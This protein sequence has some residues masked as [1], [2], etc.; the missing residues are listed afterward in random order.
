ML[1]QTVRM[2]SNVCRTAMTETMCYALRICKNQDVELEKCSMDINKVHPALLFWCP[3]LSPSQFP[4]LVVISHTPLLLRARC[5]PRQVR[6]RTEDVLKQLGLHPNELAE[7]EREGVE[8]VGG[9]VVT[10]QSEGL[11]DGYEP[12]VHNLELL[13]FG[14]LILEHGFCH[15]VLAAS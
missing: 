2:Q 9:R 14:L 13:G 1:P 10:M 11:L 6:R 12:L 5:V 15:G 3:S 7:L 8:N 4:P